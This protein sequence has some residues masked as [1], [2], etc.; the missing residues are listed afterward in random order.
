[1]TNVTFNRINSL[2]RRCLFDKA[3]SNIRPAFIF[4]FIL[5]EWLNFS[6]NKCKKTRTPKL[7]TPH[8]TKEIEHYYKLRLQLRGDLRRFVFS[9]WRWNC[10][11]LLKLVWGSLSGLEWVSSDLV[12]NKFIATLHSLNLKKKNK[13]IIRAEAASAAPGCRL[14][15][16][17]VQR[18]PL[19]DNL[20]TKLFKMSAMYSFNLL[21]YLSRTC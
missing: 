3:F 5:F 10:V 7:G 1:M 11:V 19:R 9:G 17:R 14:L 20:L 21:V 18:S 13:P 2:R 6:V 4:Y 15:T 16:R 8:S 12:P